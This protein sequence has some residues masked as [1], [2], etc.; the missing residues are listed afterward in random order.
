MLVNEKEPS[1]TLVKLMDWVKDDE[2]LISKVNGSIWVLMPKLDWVIFKSMFSSRINPLLV[3][4]TET[5][6][7]EVHFRSL[8]ENDIFSM[9]TL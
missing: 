3:M 4:F 1:E 8:L 2:S 6:I 5:F 7:G 9:M